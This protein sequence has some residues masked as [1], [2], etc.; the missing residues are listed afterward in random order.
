MISLHS[1]TLRTCWNPLSCFWSRLIHSEGLF[2]SWDPAI[3]FWVSFSDENPI[4]LLCFLEQFG[5]CSICCMAKMHK[6]NMKSCQGVQR[7]V[8]H[9]SHQRLLEPLSG[10]GQALIVWVTLSLRPAEWT[11]V[12]YYMLP[13]CF[14]IYKESHAEHLSFYMQG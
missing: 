4:D 14:L 13:L 2:G 7:N 3:L 10:R 6:T 8:S 12:S 1:Q 11:S 9:A 5:C